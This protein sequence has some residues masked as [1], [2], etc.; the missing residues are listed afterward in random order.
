MS[1]PIVLIH[2]AW[3]GAWAFD[4]VVDLLRTRDFAV[5]TI[6]LPLDGVRNDIAAARALIE[7]HPGAVVLGHSYGGLVITHAAI[8]LPVSH[9]VYLAAMMPD[10]EEDVTASA[11][12]ARQSLLQSAFRPQPDGR[13]AVDPELSVEVFYHDCDPEDA[14]GAA[15]QLRPMLMDG[16]PV[17]H[18]EPAWRTIPS[19]YIVCNNDKALHP[20]A[21]RVFANR[22]SH[23]VDWEVAH[24]PFVNRPEMAVEILAGLAN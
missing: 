8:G 21:Q 24:S 2:G 20:R 1:K 5:H 6:D 18:G 11:A 14:R 13:I 9:L 23:Q 7:Q 22:A 4:R 12:T 17:L 19:T 16:F 3:H 15:A 10:S